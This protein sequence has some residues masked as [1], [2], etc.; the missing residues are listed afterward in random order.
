MQCSIYR[1]FN[2]EYSCIFRIHESDLEHSVISLVTDPESEPANHMIVRQYFRDGLKYNFSVCLGG[3]W[4]DRMVSPQWWVEWME[5]NIIFGAQQIII[6]NMTMPSFMDPYAQ[7]YVKRGILEVLPWNL[8]PIIKLAGTKSNLQLTIT[9]D[10][11]YRMRGRSVYMAQF[12]QDELIV[13]RHP[14]DITWT[15][16]IKRSGCVPGACVY[17][18]RQVYYGRQY[19]NNTKLDNAT[20]LMM[21]DATHRGENVFRDGC[22]SKY[23]ADTS[24]IV[25]PHTHHANCAKSP[26][27]GKS[28]P[29]CTLPVEIGGSHHYRWT[30]IGQV[31]ERDGV[32]FDNSTLKY[33]DILL[34]ICT[35]TMKTINAT[36]KFP[37]QL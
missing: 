31:N 30:G 18:A 19:T 10:C 11:F 37:A 28:L 5:A 21:L 24:K 22:R 1:F 4:H 6:H 35:E 9:Y 2:V 3:A 27:T 17:G 15:D 33:K 16:M 20:G 7:H 29:R 12:D 13:P 25:F 34:Q 14:D 36:F 23:I 26:T 8:D 32:V